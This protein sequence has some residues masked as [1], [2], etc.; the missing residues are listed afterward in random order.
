MKMITKSRLYI[1]V[2]FIVGIFPYTVNCQCPTEVIVNINGLGSQVTV[3]PGAQL[4][5]RFLYKISNEQSTP[6]VIDQIMVGLENQYVGCVFS[7]MPAVCPSSTSNNKTLQFAAPSVPG[8]YRIFYSTSMDYSCK[9]DLYKPATQ[10]GTLTVRNPCQMTVSLTMNSLGNNITL[11]PGTEIKMQ[12]DYTISNEAACPGCID[13]ILFGIENQYLDC[14]YNNVPKVC[15]SATTGS[16][17][18]SFIGP[19]A[20]G[21]YK[22]YY[23]FTQDYNCEAKLY[24]PVN[25]IGTIHIPKPVVVNPVTP[26]DETR[27]GKLEA[28]ADDSKKINPG[29]Y[30]ALIIGVSKY[31]NERLNLDKPEED[32][33][34]LRDVLVSRYTF[35]DS[36]ITMMMSPTRERILEQLLILRKKIKP[37]DNLLIFYAGHGTYDEA[38]EQGYWFPADAQPD[39]PAYWISNSDLKEQIKSIKSMHTLLISDACFS[40]GIF[41]T[42][43]ITQ[44][45]N[46]PNDI[47]QLYDMPSR[48]AMTSGTL[49]E[50]PDRSAFLEYLNK[51]LIQNNSKYLASQDLFYKMRGAVIGN[52]PVVPQTGIIYQAGDEG[53]DFIFVLKE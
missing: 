24:R 34:A 21:D 39:N 28:I 25:H 32:A 1:L 8:T 4:N 15:P 45:K 11:N 18:K 35:S 22:I 36:T 44:L 50:V 52:S 43:D 14:I 51:N 37:V 33:K 40:G 41:K 3:E 16:F 5:A 31:K 19:S 42:R 30:Y 2:C 7:G 48:R 49:T 46:A 53:G 13:Q 38:A 47:Q 27:G 6:T 17:I 12:F 29:K 23:S 20:P 9:P 26:V 10:V